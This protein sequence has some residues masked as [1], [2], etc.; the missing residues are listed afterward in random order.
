MIDEKELGQR[1][2]M[3]ERIFDTEKLT[4]RGQDAGDIA[5][6][7]RQSF[8]GYRLLHSE[9]GSIHMA[10][11]P[12][13]VFDRQGYYGQPKAV[14]S[15]FTAS[16]KAV[17]ELASG[18]GFNTRYLAATYPAIAFT[19]IDLVPSEVSFATKRAGKLHNLS[20]LQGNF[21]KLPFEDA[22]FDLAYVVE[23]LCHAT[24]M[25]QALA[26][27]QRVLRPGG[28][29]IV[30]DAWQAT[31]YNQ[32]SP[33][34]QRAATLTQRAMA[35]GRPWKLD[36]W[37]QATDEAGFVQESDE[38]LTMAILP[39]L[40]RFE[41]M[42]ARYFAHPVLARMAAGVIPIRLIQNAIAGYLMPLTVAAGAHTYRMIVLKRPCPPEG[43]YHDESAARKTPTPGVWSGGDG[44]RNLDRPPLPQD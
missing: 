21:Q 24:D 43:S 26:E 22:S 40:K 41:R 16:T 18:N 35:V 10:L 17:L 32:L 6:Y 19:G 38:D 3:I 29:F 5:Q 20:Y 1:L 13:G 12:D 36:A 8:W 39:N 37:L 7:Y 31:V 42:A 28:L 9:Q 4:G 2:A 11:N 14:A 33:L 30:V 44:D 15:W 27:A 34:V 25:H 23:S